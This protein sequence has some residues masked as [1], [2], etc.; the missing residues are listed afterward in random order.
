MKIENPK[1]KNYFICRNE[2]RKI[3][4]YGEIGTNNTME[5]FLPIVDTYLNREEWQN[6]LNDNGIIIEEI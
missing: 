5:T 3:I 4:S 1:E 2:N 6:I